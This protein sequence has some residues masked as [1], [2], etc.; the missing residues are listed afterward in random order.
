MGNSGNYEHSIAISGLTKV[1]G[2]KKLLNEVEI[3]IPRGA[4]TG[5]V[6]PNGA[7][8][9]TTMKAILGLTKYQ[10]GAG[11][12]C[13]IDINRP[14][15]YLQ[16]VGAL[17]ETPAFYPHLTGE[18]NLQISARSC[19]ADES[20]INKL[21]ERV[22]LGNA[23][24]KL[25]S[26]YSLGMKQRLGIAAA[27]LKEPEVLILDEPV[28]GLDPEA[29]ISIR[30]MVEEHK[31][32]GGSVLIS[33]HLLKELEV[34]SDHFIFIDNGE[35]TFSGSKDE[36]YE[37]GEK[38]ILIKPEYRA[39]L[40]QLLTLIHSEKLE[41]TIEGDHIE[42]PVHQPHAHTLSAEL[43]RKAHGWGI[44]LSELSISVQSLE[45]RFF[46]V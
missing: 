43:D 21:L 8:K 46:A 5:F 39:D 36:L 25:F 10:T 35:I 12:V 9:T 7:G 29:V 38:K 17:I 24:G 11:E 2:E 6:G 45:E 20:H 14:E 22:G 19:G 3:V 27:F 32:N 34:I 44:W 15:Q 16:Y 42:I 4:I 33:S 30:H 26:Q 13:G 1:L 28:N 37:S 40:T 18:Y 23:V 31:D 41:A